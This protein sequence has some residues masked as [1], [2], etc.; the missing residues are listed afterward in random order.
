MSFALLGHELR[1]AL[2]PF[3]IFF[4][5]LV[6]YIAVIVSMFDPALGESLNALAASM[7]ELFAAFG[8]GAQATTLDDFMLNYLYGFLLTVLPFVLIVLLVNRAVVQRIERGTMACLLATPVSRVRIAGSMACA[9]VVTL[10]AMLALTLATGLVCAE[11]LF[12]GELDAARLVRAHVGLLGPWLFL[13][14]LCLLSACALPAPGPALWAGGGI[15]IGLFLLQ[16]VAQVGDAPEVLTRVNPLELYD[17]FALANG[18][19]GA[20]VGA[21]VLAAVGVVLIAGAVAVFARRDL[22]V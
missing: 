9:L 14:G 6:M 1:R 7:P 17:P 11:L 12:P 16:M 3:V 10:V 4:G 20:I 13:A 8:M 18:E 19:A 15:G 21:I 22:S 5:V 2:L